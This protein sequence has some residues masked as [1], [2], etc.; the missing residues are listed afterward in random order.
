LRQL[1][2]NSVTSCVPANSADEKNLMPQV[3][4]VSRK[5]KGRSSEVLLVAQHIPEYFAD[6]DDLHRFPIRFAAAKVEIMQA[7][8][9]HA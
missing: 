3:C 8:T 5:I 6:A 1:L 7:G 4:E 9:N 2:D